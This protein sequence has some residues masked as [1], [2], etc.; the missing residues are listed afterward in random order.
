ML[1]GLFMR[2]A[3]LLCLALTI[4]RA[5]PGVSVA[6]PVE[7]Y[8]Q[9]IAV[10]PEGLRHIPSAKWTKVQREA[11]NARFHEVFADKKI[12]VKMRLKVA[13]VANW[14]GMTLYSEIT[15]EGGCHVR[16]FGKFTDQW[17][18]K[19]TALKKKDGVILEGA[20]SSVSYGDLWGDFTLGINVADCSFER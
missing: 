6:K 20:I 4:A 16:V 19:L 7:S 18:P 5:E 14:D 1:Q 15:S 9:I 3:L 13:E 10:L 11:A 8:Q 12:P 2:I 17:K